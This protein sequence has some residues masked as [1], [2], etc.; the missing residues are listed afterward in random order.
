LDG[1]SLEW[2]A[3]FMPQEADFDLLDTAARLRADR[4]ATDAWNRKR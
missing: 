3:A 4:F 2:K 1:L